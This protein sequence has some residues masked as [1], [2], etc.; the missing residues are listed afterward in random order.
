MAFKV[1]YVDKNIAISVI[2]TWGCLSV[3]SKGNE[4]QN[5]APNVTLN[6]DNN[7]SFI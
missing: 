6:P 7:G 5:R 4:E 2:F 1:R 3:K